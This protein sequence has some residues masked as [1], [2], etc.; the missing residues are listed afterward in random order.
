MTNKKYSYLFLLFN[1]ILVALFFSGCTYS[2]N[3]INN[4]QAIVITDD[5]GYNTTISSGIHHVIS[6]S[7]SE[8][9]IFYA[10]SPETQGISLVGRTDYDT[11]PSKVIN[12]TSVGGPQTL[13][14]EAIAGLD[15]DL[16]LTTTVADETVIDQ[17]RD[18]EYPVLIFNPE[19]FEGIYHNIYAVGKALGLDQQA[20][21]LVDSLQAGVDD[22]ISSKPAEPPEK[23][24]FV[25]TVQPFYVAG[26]NTF[27]NEFI[28]TSGGINIFGDQSGYFV[29]SDE[30]IVNR[31]PDVIIVPSTVTDKGLF[32]DQILQMKEIASV[33]AIKNGKICVIDENVISRP[34]PRFVEGLKEVDR[35]I[36]G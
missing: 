33:P 8:T 30:E 36:N 3:K 7:P 31:S 28:T 14:V 32:K 35:C 16:I 20:K 1:L 26:N 24:M 25:V 4:S 21:T 22:V 27:P 17:L 2:E 12:V 9:E 5:T 18:L 6:L 11:Y 23:V 34:G 29:A 10:L 13:S 15:P 19:S